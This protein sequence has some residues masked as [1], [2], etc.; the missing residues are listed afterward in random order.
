M[1]TPMSPRAAASGLPIMPRSRP[2]C[3]GSKARRATSRCPP[4]SV[5]RVVGGVDHDCGGD[6]DPDRHEHEAA[7]DPKPGRDV[8]PALAVVLRLV[9]SVGA[10]AALCEAAD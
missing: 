3:G 10:A 9:P 8:A 4:D 7:G 5:G 1:P 2:G 6:D